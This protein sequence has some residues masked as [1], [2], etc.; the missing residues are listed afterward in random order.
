[1]FCKC[2]YTFNSF[3]ELKRAVAEKL[4]DFN[5]EAFQKR[6]GSRYEVWQEEKQYLR[7]LPSM[8]Y[9]VAEWVYGRAINLDF[10]VVY[11]KNRYSCPYQYAKKKDHK[12]D[13]R[14]TSSMIEIYYKGDRIAT[15]HRF[16]DYVSNKYSTHP[17]D[18]PKAFRDIVDWDDQRIRN[19]A[20]SIGES[21]A[22][23]IEKIFN[24]VDIKEQGYAVLNTAA[25]AVGIDYPIGT[26]TMRKTFGYWHYRQHRDVALLQQIFGH[27]SPSVTLILIT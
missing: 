10:H 7:D 13:L 8:P 18:M 23:V 1:M 6:E 4:R 2:E 12:V 3:A 22:A 14:V 21:T 11:K 25:E 9:E 15:H 16:P 5:H 26:H 20:R 19:W 17:E 24:S 27:S